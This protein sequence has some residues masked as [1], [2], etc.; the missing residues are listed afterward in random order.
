M[1][2]LGGRPGLRWGACSPSRRRCRGG[3]RRPPPATCCVLFPR[4]VRVAI[5]RLPLGRAAASPWGYELPS[6][7]RCRGRPRRSPSLHPLLCPLV[8]FPGGANR[9]AAVG[10]R[11]REGTATSP[12]GTRPAA[13]LL[14]SS[15]AARSR[16]LPCVVVLEFPLHAYALR[17][18]SL[19]N[20]PGPRRGRPP[21]GWGS[22]PEVRFHRRG[23][24]A[25]VRCPPRR[26]LPR[27][28]GPRP[29]DQRCPPTRGPK[30]P[31]HAPLEASCQPPGRGA[32]VLPTTLRAS[33]RCW[34][35]SLL[36]TLRGPHPP[37]RTMHGERRLGLW[38]ESEGGRAAAIH[39]FAV[40]YRRMGQGPPLG[41]AAFNRPPV[42]NI[43][44]QRWVAQEG[45]ESRT[46]R[47]NR[48][49]RRCEKI[50]TWRGTEERDR[51]RE[52]GDGRVSIVAHSS[53]G[54]QREG[55]R[56]PVSMVERTF[57]RSGAQ[58]SSWRARAVSVEQAK[59]SCTKVMFI[60]QPGD[61]RRELVDP[62]LLE[63]P[64]QRASRGR[65]T[66]YGW[67]RRRGGDARAILE[68][69]RRPRRRGATDGPCRGGDIICLHHEDTASAPGKRRR[70]D[71]LAGWPG[72]P[73]QRANETRMRNQWVEAK[74]VWKPGGSSASLVG[75]RAR[76]GSGVSHLHTPSPPRAAAT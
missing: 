75:H 5:D 4:S 34:G 55:G 25:V 49:L 70:N 18:C 69:S 65:G 52:P 6:R 32:D 20:T 30:R 9:R 54:L 37:A 3:G 67:M 39:G 59:T 47:V 2:P 27:A 72:P 13:W 19:G 35:P 31:D 14:E 51:R 28:R 71:H 21:P 7:R 56:T 68:T 50:Q 15:A 62:I 22:P 42:Q 16:H 43:R 57:L 61:I 74:G 38:R 26:E 36:A 12:G 76:V 60:P 1:G 48:R 41:T 53:A 24:A 46:A 10:G 64:R 8:L 17:G 58:G 29:F 63:A 40:R 44:P 45:R 11:P 73:P 33:G 23:G 66:P